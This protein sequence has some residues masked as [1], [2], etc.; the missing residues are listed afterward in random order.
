MWEKAGGRESVSLASWPSYDES[1]T[2][3]DE[4]TI[5]VQVN[6]K[7]RDK[8]TAAAG[9]GKEQLEKTALALAGVVK[10]T[11]GKRITKVVSVPGKLVSIVAAD[12]G[13]KA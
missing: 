6:G 3:D 1:L 11:T 8:F 4:S 2:A 7:I 13:E 10:W 12:T 9:T 5:V